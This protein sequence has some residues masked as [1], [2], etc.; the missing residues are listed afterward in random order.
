[1]GANKEILKNKDQVKELQLIKLKNRKGTELEILNF[2]ATIFSLKIN[3][4]NVI[5]GPA[6]PEDYLTEVYHKRGKYFG[7]TVGRH[8]GR[9]SKGGFKLKD[10][11]H[12]IFER[13]GVHLHGGEY[14]FTYKFW[15]IVER[16]EKKDPFVVLHYS[17][18]DGEEGYPGNL[19]V[20]VKYTLSEEDEI[21]I[22]YSAETDKETV[23]NLTNHAYFNLNG[24]GDVDDHK[25]QI[26]ADQYLETD[27]QKVPTG[28]MLKTAGTEYDFRKPAAIGEIALDT[29]FK[30]KKDK[31]YFLLKGN[32][33]GITLEVKTNQ[34]GVVVYV[35]EDLPTDW[36]YSTEIGSERAAICL[37]TQK[38][39]DAPHQSKFPSV[40]LNPGENYTNW[41]RWKFKNGS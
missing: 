6:R 19:K 24:G 28:K 40:V 36:E 1:M 41:T 34:P 12:S 15:A 26:P 16:D 17:S 8:A 9:I 18:P 10:E 20:Q 2:G 22:E 4:I 14:G 5:V 25:L 13:D 21:L 31:K 35:P 7:A 37:E 11:K 27:T 32:V 38:F 33:T 23:V 30:L 29:T 3:G 39:P